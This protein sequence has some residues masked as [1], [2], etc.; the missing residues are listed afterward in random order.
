[1]KSLLLLLLP[2]TAIFYVLSSP[3]EAACLEIQSDNTFSS[4]INTCN[5]EVYVNWTDSH[6]CSNWRCASSLKPFQKSPASITR[7]SV[8]SWCEWYD[9]ATGKGPCD[10]A[11]RQPPR[12]EIGNAKCG[13]LAEYINKLKAALPKAEANLARA[14]AVVDAGQIPGNK[15]TTG[16]GRYALDTVSK[17]KPAIAKAREEIA[18]GDRDLAKCS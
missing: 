2:V 16:Y 7:K 18:R 14:Q 3:A 10:G 1:M 15:D 13:E 4:W 6:S 9:G 12:G 11:S 5:R 8:T 17:L